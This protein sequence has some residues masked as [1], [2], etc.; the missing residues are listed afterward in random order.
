VVLADGTFVTADSQSH[1]DL[2][3]ALRGGGGNFGVVTSFEFRAH[4][5]HTVLGGLR[6]Y[7]RS[8][9][10]DVIRF[11]R[12]YIE[13]APDDLSA[14]AALLHAPD[15]APLIG[16]IAC[17]CGEILEGERV[18][19]PLRT[20]GAPVLDTIQPMPFPVMQSLLETSFPDGNY[21]YWKSTL[22]RNLPDDAIAA[23][24][25]HGNRM[26]SP[27]SAVVLEYYGGAAARVPPD[28]TAYPHRDLPWD[29]LFVA[30]W[31]DPAQMAAQRDWA[32]SGEA[33]LRPFSANAH[34]LSA[35]D[36]E[37]EEVI[38]TAFGPNLLRL[39][40]VKK[41][42]DPTNFFRVNQNIR[43]ELAQAGGA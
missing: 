8:A 41:R 2:F 14:Y 30:Q 35:L 7:P 43:P 18:L 36:I 25:E 22:Q 21:N 38:H 24:I 28:A 37:S 31:T 29:I 19:Q 3:W 20:F 40:A 9:A 10:V 42:Y 5:V 26:T 13:A 27:L 17:Y 32:R 6:L 4:P 1:P 34:L 23:I 15:G 33:I 12:D 39:S 11:F 16:V